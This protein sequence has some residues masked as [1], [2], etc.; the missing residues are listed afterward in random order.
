MSKD[1]SVLPTKKWVSAKRI[2]GWHRGPRG[3]KCVSLDGILFL[4]RVVPIAL[5]KLPT[6]R[7]MGLLDV[8]VNRLI[9][10]ERILSDLLHVS[11]LD[12][13][14]FFL[15]CC[16]Q[17]YGH[18]FPASLDDPAVIDTVGGAVSDRCES[19][20]FNLPLGWVFDELQVLSPE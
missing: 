17:V 5:V 12:Q 20:V 9:F 3:L 6:Q 16:D 10:F 15:A 4:A 7:R 1:T 19:T 18:V 11:F 2:R 8:K 13:W 14:H